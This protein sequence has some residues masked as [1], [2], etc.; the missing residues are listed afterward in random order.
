MK[1]LV[2]K[3]LDLW[4][5]LGNIGIDHSADELKKR[6][7]VVINHIFNISTLIGLIT[8]FRSI[9]KFEIY[10]YRLLL[11]ALC[12]VLVGCT[13]IR[14]QL[15]RS[16]WNS[17]YLRIL[18]ILIVALILA[19][20]VLGGRTAGIHYFLIGAIV[21]PM[22]ALGV[23]DKALVLINAFILIPVNVL[24]FWW[25]ENNP[26]L[27]KLPV[28]TSYNYYVTVSIVSVLIFLFQY[29]QWIE[30]IRA[31]QRMLS[32]KEKADSLLL[33][34]LPASIADELKSEGSV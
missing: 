32:E 18:Y 27:I 22:F 9:L 17:I 26:P 30:T 13:F 12:I 31:N 1:S 29:I 23:E 3:A 10:S 14:F 11:I 34:I 24:I 33:N 20:A 16:N 21:L 28:G 8:V 4:R 7:Q 2:L 5:Y 19:I 25:V 15:A 6:K